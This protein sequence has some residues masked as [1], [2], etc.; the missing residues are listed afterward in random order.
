MWIGSD[1]TLTICGTIDFTHQI[2]TRFSPG[3]AISSVLEEHLTGQQDGLII[4]VT[5]LCSIVLFL[6]ISPTRY[7]HKLIAY[8]GD[9]QN[10]ISWLNS[11]KA[12]NPLARFLLRLLYRLELKYQFHVYPLYIL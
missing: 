7:Q 6:M 11:R 4:A 8:T 1:A 3:E 12:G 5:E 2:Y 9:N 10:V